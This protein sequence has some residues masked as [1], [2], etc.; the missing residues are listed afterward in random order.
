M[1][2][3]SKTKIVVS[4]RAG[5]LS[6]N[7]K[8]CYGEQEIQIVLSFE[9]LGVTVSAHGLSKPAAEEEIRKSNMAIGLT[10]FILA[11][12]KTDSTL[13]ICK[14]FDAMTTA[15]LLYTAPIWA[16]PYVDDNER[17]QTQL[18]RRIFG[19][20]KTTARRPYQS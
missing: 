16:I 20:P 13:C 4:R 14:L 10:H 9:Y 8:F 5:R 1:V 6:A 2:N 19:L 7:L 3:A 15:T 17:V 11:K 12:M 18:F